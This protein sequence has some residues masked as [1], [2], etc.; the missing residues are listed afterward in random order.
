VG[1]TVEDAQLN[2]EDS[3][4]AGDLTNPTML[5]RKLRSIREQKREQIAPLCGDNSPGYQFER[6][7]GIFEGDDVIE[8]WMT[9]I[10]RIGELGLVVPDT[11]LERWMH[12]TETVI[13]EG[14]QGVLLDADAGF[15]PFT[16][17]SRCTAANAFELI[18]EMAPGSG[19]F[20]IGVMRSYAVRHG[21]G[22]LP[23]ETDVL[24]TIISEH[25]EYNEWQGAVRYGWFDAVLA[26]YALSLTGR[27]DSL[28][29]THLDV[30]SRLE[31]W[32]Y[33]VGY[34]GFHDPDDIFVNS[35]VT[36]GVL[37]SLHLPR[38]LSLEQR[39][40]FTQALSTVTPVLETCDANE[41]RVIQ[42]IESLIGQP[43][44]II[45]HGPSAKNIQILNSI[46]S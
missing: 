31:T 23:T 30:L 42:R 35:D 36:N 34:K 29:V 16:T 41:G 2:A 20:Q 10:S 1:E 3:V 39:A 24:T 9:S 43:V 33:C 7:L 32:K 14:A 17:W 45:S 25:N 44:D 11:V 5:R 12:E 15:H 27:I 18:T 6:E 19:V 37:A 22:P 8:A 46:P 4:L 38:F 13:F 40:Q 26:R 28:A 21:P